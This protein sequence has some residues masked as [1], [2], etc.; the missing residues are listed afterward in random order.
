MTLVQMAPIIMTFFPLAV[1]VS[2]NGISSKIL[3]IV[4][5]IISLVL[6]PIVL[7]TRV[8]IVVSNIGSNY[9]YTIMILGSIIDICF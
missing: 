2:L 6:T 1:E 9:T 4:L 8:V 5:I 7:T 3:A